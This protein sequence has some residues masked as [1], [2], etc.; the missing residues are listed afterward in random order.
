M[1]MTTQFQQK[2][3]HKHDNP[4]PTIHKQRLILFRKGDA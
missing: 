2:P 4:N 3:Q 1:N